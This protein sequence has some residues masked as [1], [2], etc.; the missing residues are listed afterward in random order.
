MILKIHGAIDRG[1]ESHDSFVVS[2]D[3][4]IEY[5]TH[6]NLSELVPV[7][8]L[9]RLRRS[10]FLFLGHRMRDWNLRAM[11]HRICSASAITVIARGPSSSPRTWWTR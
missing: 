8:V 7:S 4:Y 11:L 10:H 1:D 3:H 2:E 9:A 6:S 5:L